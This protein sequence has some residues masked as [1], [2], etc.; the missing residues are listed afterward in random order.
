MTPPDRPITVVLVD[1]HPVVR[2]GLRALIESFG[3]FTVVGEAADGEQAVREVQLSRPDVVVMDVMMPH[4]DGVEATRR[5]VRA[6]P[7]T[8]VLV[9]SMAEEDDVVF[10]AMQAGARGYLLKGAAQ[11][12]IE[13]ALRAVVAGEAIFGPGIASRVL[14]VF[15]RDPAERADPFPGLTARERDVLELVAQG[16][17]NA[18]IADALGMAPKT[19]ANHLSSIF[20]KLQVTDRSAAIVRARD[21][22]L[23]RGRPG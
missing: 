10:G 14:G 8:A 2:G 9:L 7:A 1:D 23:G 16:R 5:I 22:G 19:V 13:R 17:R 12:E 3:G 18:V 20:G 21:G 4:V 15:G 6:C 11:E